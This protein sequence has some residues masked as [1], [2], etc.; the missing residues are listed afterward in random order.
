MPDNNYKTGAVKSNP[1]KGFSMP[2][3]DFQSGQDWI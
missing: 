2:T 1:N 3:S